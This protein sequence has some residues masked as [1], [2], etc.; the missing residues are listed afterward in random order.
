M[1]V[2]AFFGIAFLWNWNENTFS[3]PV[4]TA[5]FSKFAGI[6]SAA[7]TQHHLSGFETA[8]LEFHTSKSRLKNNNFL[9][10]IFSFTTI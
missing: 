6:V 4:A 2:S 10:S 7:L 3:S 9:K 5:G 1:V 8:Q